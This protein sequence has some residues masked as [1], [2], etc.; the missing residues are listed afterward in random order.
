MPRAAQGRPLGIDLNASPLQG[1]ELDGDL[2]WAFIAPGHRGPPGAG[3]SRGAVNGRC[4]ASEAWWCTEQHG[5]RRGM[6]AQLM[7]YRFSVK[8]YQRMREADILVVFQTCWSY[9]ITNGYIM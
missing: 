4:R 2:V 8:D 9:S 6:A 1:S 7:T 3:G 5:G